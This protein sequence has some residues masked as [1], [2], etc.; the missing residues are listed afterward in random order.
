MASIEKRITKN[1]DVSYRITICAGLDQSGK[2]IRKRMNYTPEAGM[3]ERQIEKEVQKQAFLFE[4]QF[5]A[6]YELGDN[7]CFSEYADY[8]LSLKL[9][10]GMK[11]S[12]YDRYMT[13]IP[14]INKAIGFMHLRDIRPIHLNNFYDQMM[15][16]GVRKKGSRA[17]LTCE[18]APLLKSRGLSRSKFS[19]ETGISMS[20]VSAISLHHPV[21]RATAEKAAAYFGKRYSDLFRTIHDDSK[22][23]GNKT[24]LEYHRL[25][26]SILAQAEKEMIVPYNAAKKATPPKNV[27]K[28]VNYFQPSQICDILTAL[29]SEPLM[30]QLLG[31]LLMITGARRGEIAGLKWSKIDIDRHLVKIDSALLQSDSIG[32]YESTTKTGNVRYIPLPQETIDLLERYRREQDLF[33]TA[34]GDRWTE[35]GFVFTRE[36]GSPIRP[37]GI[38]QWFSDFSRRHKLPHVNPHAFRHTA[39]SV[40]ISHG[41]DIVTVSKMLGHANVS[42][43]EDIYSHVI[44]ESKVLA[45]NLLAEIYLRGSRPTDGFSWNSKPSDPVWS[46]YGPRRLKTG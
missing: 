1:G 30:W 32:I 41:S 11:R 38:T 24:V 36:D 8:V 17:V 39:A 31:H 7:R 19:E 10:N 25:I 27:R 22:P 2:K 16:P 3:S 9:R 23:L 46:P 43:T 21:R 29:E 15:K 45:S 12:T 20:T 18:L 33:R 35:Y 34:M 6:G 44:E 4:Q 5:N 13:L 37:D 14:E 26:S 42:T 28:E 40:L